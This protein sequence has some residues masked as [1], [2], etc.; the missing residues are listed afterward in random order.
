VQI[1]R[2]HR[3]QKLLRIA[4]HRYRRYNAPIGEPM[5]PGVCLEGGMW[6]RNYTMAVVYINPNVGGPALSATLDSAFAYHDL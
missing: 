3:P 4:E 5:G 6:Q 1:P 2:T